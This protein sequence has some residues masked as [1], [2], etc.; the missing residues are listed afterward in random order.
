MPK[1]ILQKVR[2]FYKDLFKTSENIKSIHIPEEI[3]AK[4]KKYP[5]QIKKYEK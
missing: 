4:V 3:L 2:H 5:A 1:E